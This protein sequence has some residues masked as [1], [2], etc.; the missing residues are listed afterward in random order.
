M[1]QD[2]NL[3]SEEN[4]KL[5]LKDKLKKT[6]SVILFSS[7]APG[8]GTYYLGYF[9][10]S[11]SLILTFWTSLFLFYQNFFSESF[12]VKLALYLLIIVS[13]ILGF[14]ISIFIIFSNK[15]IVK[16]KFNRWFQC[17]LIISIQTSLI[18]FAPRKDIIFNIPTG[19]MEPTI[20]IG[21]TILTT[22]NISQI[23][24]GDIVTF[25]LPKDPSLSFV[26]RVIGIP[27]DVI[28]IINKE[29][30]INGQIIEKKKIIK[31]KIKDPF[32]SNYYAKK[33]NFFE[34]TI[35]N[36]TFYIIEDS[37]ATHSDNY[38]RTVVPEN[39]YFVMGD[40]RDNSADSRIWGFI[41]RQNIF[42]KPIYI[43]INIFDFKFERA[44]TRIR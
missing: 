21:E 20:Q 30:L 16:T 17:I 9:K 13:T 32:P 40:Q 25:K 18:V 31:S 22:P 19:S 4:I 23:N 14:I 42:V 15:T 12:E 2:E 5:S 35:E 44:G 38:P 37:K 11:F 8:M 6:L 34:T 7:M 29:L 33:Y 36:K 27:G 3:F 28:E 39:N 10:I 43:F 26:K 41:P 24:R 1:N